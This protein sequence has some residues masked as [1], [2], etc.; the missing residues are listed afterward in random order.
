[1]IVH[2]RQALAVLA[3]LMMLAVLTGV[4]GCGGQE[5][6]GTTEGHG[7]GGRPP[8]RAVPVAVASVGTG[9][10][11]SYYRATATLEAQQEA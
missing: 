7:R 4:F 9:E 1:M 2:A 6:A 10:I 3:S 11:A 5:E 8:Q